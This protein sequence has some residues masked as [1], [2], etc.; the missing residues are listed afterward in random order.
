VHNAK[1][2]LLKQYAETW[3]TMTDQDALIYVRHWME[4]DEEAQALRLKYVQPMSQ[5]LPGKKA[6]TF[7]QLE[8]KLCMM[9]DLQ[10][11]SQ[12]PLAHEK[13]Q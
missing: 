7:F 12:V 5:V 4:V 8:R 9:V 3:A 1:Y 10:L 2:A 6:A 13:Q 11:F